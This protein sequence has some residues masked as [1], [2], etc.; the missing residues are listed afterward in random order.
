MSKLAIFQTRLSQTKTWLTEAG[1][2]PAAN[3]AFDFP[4]V[5]ARVREWYPV[6]PS[7]ANRL[8]AKAARQ[9]RGETVP[10]DL[11]GRNYSKL[12]L[13]TGDEVELVRIAGGEATGAESYKVTV[14][15]ADGATLTANGEHDDLH[16]AKRSS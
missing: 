5:V 1:F 7:R 11:G 8:L 6:Q 9:L 15:G 3:T 16:L 12:T 10:N 14:S 4:N 2:D 13:R